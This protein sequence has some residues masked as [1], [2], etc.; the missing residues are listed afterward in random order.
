MQVP[1]GTCVGCLKD[2][3]ND[4]IYRMESE[5]H[6]S[7]HSLFVTLTYDESNLPLLVDT[8]QGTRIL[9]YSDYVKQK[10]IYNCIPQLDRKDF[11]NYMKRL[12]KE[13]NYDPK[14]VK[15]KYYACG[16][17]GADPGATKRPHFHFALFYDKLNPGIVEY[18]IN[19]VWNMGFCTIEPLISNRIAYLC[20]YILK[21]DKEAKEFDEQNAPFQASSHGL[22]VQ[23]FLEDEAFMPQVEAPF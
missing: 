6:H 11:T 22:G 13:L 19:K 4:W 2:R 16:E 5:M 3:Q 17:Y 10:A 18:A 15:F 20:K 1:C 12:R 7:E 14:E 9:R 23:G 21:G 8:P